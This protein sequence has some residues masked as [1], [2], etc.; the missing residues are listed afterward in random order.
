MASQF[1]NVADI[2]RLFLLILGEDPDNPGSQNSPLNAMIAHQRCASASEFVPTIID[3][4]AGYTAVQPVFDNN[5]NLTSN[6][7]VTTAV[8]RTSLSALRWNATPYAFDDANA[9]KYKSEA[10]RQLGA[11]MAAKSAAERDLVAQEKFKQLKRMRLRDA[12]RVIND[13]RMSFF[14]ANLRYKAAAGSRYASDQGKFRPLDLDGDGWAISS[15]YIPSEVTHVETGDTAPDG[16]TNVISLP[17]L[18]ATK[19]PYRFAE[20]ADWSR[21]AYVDKPDTLDTIVPTDNQPMWVCYKDIDPDV[22][23]SVGVSLKR[24]E[25]DSAFKDHIT[26]VEDEAAPSSLTFPNGGPARNGYTRWFYPASRVIGTADRRAFIPP[27]T[28]FSVTGFLTFEK[29]HFY[30][31]I[32]RGEVWDEW[33]KKVVDFATLESALMIDPDG[34]VYTKANNIDANGKVIDS[35]GM[36]DTAIIYQSWLNDIFQGDRDRIGDAR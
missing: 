18:N 34:N 6:P 23:A 31:V 20:P 11:P 22:L 19:R 13:M 8:A 2:D 7:S 17:I 26:Y 33:K 30:R 36:N 3:L 1:D 10:L 21:V 15:V 12:E 32:S 35:S 4:G 25:A 14:G 28:Y 16:S 9:N 27:D 29:S 5:G 24:N